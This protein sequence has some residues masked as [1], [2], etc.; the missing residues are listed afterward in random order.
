MILSPTLVMC[1]SLPPPPLRDLLLADRPR[2]LSFFLFPKR[3]GCPLAPLLSWVP[4]L[5]GEAPQQS[6]SME[7][8]IIKEDFQTGFPGVLGEFEAIPRTGQGTVGSAYMCAESR[9]ELAAGGGR[10]AC[11]LGTM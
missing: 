6:Q 2:S 3:T 8:C 7:K 10:S 11:I 5:G 1:S 9:A 4:L